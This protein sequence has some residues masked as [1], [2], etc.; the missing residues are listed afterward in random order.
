MEAQRTIKRS[1][2]ELVSKHTK[3]DKGLRNGLEQIKTLES[4]KKKLMIKLE[5]LS[6]IY[7][8]LKRD[9]ELET[10]KNKVLEQEI[11]IQKDKDICYS[12]KNRLGSKKE[13]EE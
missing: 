4:D 3:T 10:E 11:N 9:Y 1:Y 2:K 6:G 13:G 12:L 7:K 8:A 5:E